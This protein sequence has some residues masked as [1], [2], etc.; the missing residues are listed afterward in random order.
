MVERRPARPATWVSKLKRAFGRAEIWQIERA[1]RLHHANGRDP[2]EVQP[3]G[4]DLGSDDD[5][6]IASL[7]PADGGVVATKA[8]NRVTVDPHD[9]RARKQPDGFG[10]DALGSRA[11]VIERSVA[12]G[13][14]PNWAHLEAAAVA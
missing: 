6:D 8:A 13:A 5:I 1:I 12:G 10:L 9:A 2:G 14:L 11:E 7:N 3:F 4:N